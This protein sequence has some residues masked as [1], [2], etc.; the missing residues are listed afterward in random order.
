VIKPLISASKGSNDFQTPASAVVP[1]LRYLKRDWL[2][3]EPAMGKGNIVMALLR[4]GFRVRGSDIITGQD[5]LKSD[6]GLFDCIVSNP[7][8]S[9]KTEFIRKA[10]S[11]GKPWAL[12]MPLSALGARSRLQLYK[13][14]GIELLLLDKRVD[15][16]T[17]SGKG[18]GA[19]FAT[20][21]FC[22]KLLPEPLMFGEVPVLDKL[23]EPDIKL[24]IFNM[25]SSRALA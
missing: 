16:E 21:W 1:L 18:S 19:W 14:Y 10:Y 20:A 23:P 24:D 25:G 9:L 11:L 8:Y 22:W 13:Q 2:I 15:F 6:G 4:N 5:F 3:W 17:P 12:L 7:P